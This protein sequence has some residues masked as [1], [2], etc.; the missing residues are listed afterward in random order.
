MIHTSV[1]ETS[2]DIK[3]YLIEVARIQENVLI[4]KDLDRL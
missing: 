3:K 4:Q 2:D 1:A